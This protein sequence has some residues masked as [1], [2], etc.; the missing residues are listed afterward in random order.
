M[1]NKSFLAAERDSDIFQWRVAFR[2][3]VYDHFGDKK[4]STLNLGK[5]SKNHFR[6]DWMMKSLAYG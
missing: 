6:V 5:N 3:F 1:K 2:K 4:F